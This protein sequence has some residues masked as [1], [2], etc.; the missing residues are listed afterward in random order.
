MLPEISTCKIVVIGLGYV[1]L[2]L[3]I[4]FSKTEA[5]LRSKK[6]LK[7][8]IIGFDVDLE[9]IE[10]LINNND[11][12][13]EISSLELQENK[14]IFFTSNINDLYHADVYIVTVPTPIDNAKRPDINPIKKAC[15]SIGNSIKIRNKSKKSCPIII[16]ESTVYPGLTEEVCV[17]IIEQIS[18]LKYNELTSNGFA[19]GYSPE[20]I[21]PGDKVH[22][23]TNIKKV[24]SG[25]NEQVADWV[26]ELY[27]S[28]I[29]AGTYKASSIKEAEAAK[30]IENTQRDLN[31]ALINELAIIFSKMGIDTSNV[32][33]A[34]GTK[35]NFL[36]FKPGLVGGHCIGVDPYYLTYKSEE[37]GYLPEVVLAGRRINDNMASWIIEQLSM[38]MAQNS[39]IISKSKLLILGFTFKEDCKDIRNTQV[40]N[41]Y[42]KAKEYSMQIYILDPIC[43]RNQVKD[44]YGINVFNSFEELNGIKF[45]AVIA[46]VA[47]KKFQDLQPSFWKS[48]VTKE[49]II[50]DLKNIV[51]KDIV[52]MRL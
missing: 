38:S 39:F 50:Y 30:I 29:K 9:R 44:I 19:C 7:R 33:E 42:K 2:P 17:K 13:G 31:I 20:R 52:S 6:T 36:K 24:T 21:N 28:I 5:C 51:P 27:G 23:L 16:F 49:G 48:L 8:E 26:D 34:A 18:G 25:S 35:W 4:E 40:I 15:E 45:E 37:C 32:L 22:R 43:D 11:K 46:A 12:T 10:E 47:H 3:A 14:K 41:L 1:G